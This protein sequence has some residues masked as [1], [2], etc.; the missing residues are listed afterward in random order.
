MTPLELHSVSLAHHKSWPWPSKY[1]RLFEYVREVGQSAQP[2]RHPRKDLF[3]HKH[4]HSFQ[5]LSGEVMD[6]FA[7]LEDYTNGTSV[8]RTPACPAKQAANVK[9]KT[10]GSL[11]RSDNAK[12]QVKDDFVQ[13]EGKGCMSKST[14]ADPEIPSEN[15]PSTETIG[16]L[17]IASPAYLID[18]ALGHLGKVRRLRPCRNALSLD[19]TSH[20]AKVNKAA[21]A[22]PELADKDLPVRLKQTSRKHTSV[23]KPSPS[24]ATCSD[25]NAFFQGD[26]HVLYMKTPTCFFVLC[27]PKHL[28][29]RCSR[30]FRHSR[31]TSTDLSLPS[32]G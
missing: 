5:K 12:H 21:G 2:M 7:D 9:L 18:P 14:Q 20:E 1:Q 23:G 3:A 27:L 29:S 32:D 8:T 6:P 31:S 22:L 15:G 28:P 4:A 30:H 11:D 17:P 26:S 10:D 25:E 19:G 24:E 13:G 16:G